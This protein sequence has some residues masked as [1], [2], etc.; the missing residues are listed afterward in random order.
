MER[1]A[2]DEDYSAILG[3]WSSVFNGVSIISNRETIFHR[4]GQSRLAWYDIICTL[5]GDQSTVL[6]FRDLGI[7]LRYT[8]GTVVAHSGRLLYHGVSAAENERVCYAYWMRDC[9]HELMGVKSPYWMSR[10]MYAV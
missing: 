10:D 3:I 9:I 5:G 7:R 6:E 4:D 1:L 2:E 8:S